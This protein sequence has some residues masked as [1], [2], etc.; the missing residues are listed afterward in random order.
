[1]KKGTIGVVIACHNYGHF[2]EDAIYS[3]LHQTRKP[4]QI[5]LSDDHSSD[6]TGIIAKKFVTKYPKLLSYIRSKRTVGTVSTYNR[7]MQLLTTDY[8]CCL[9]ADD[10]YQKD[11][12]K[13]TGKILDTIQ[14]ISIAYTDFVL[15]GPRSEH[16]YLE[17]DQPG[18]YIDKK[19]N[20]IVRF[21]DFN[22]ETRKILEH[23][24]YIHNA[25]LVRRNSFNEA[26]GYKKAKSR[27]IDHDLFLRIL[28][29]GKEAFHVP[30]PL[31]KYRQHSIKQTS[32]KYY[33]NENY[34]NNLLPLAL[35]SQLIEE[36]ILL[37]KKII[38]LQKIIGKIT[39][40]RFYKTWQTLN[41]V[42]RKILGKK[43]N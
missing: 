32:A 14:N 17:S 27:E 38:S 18:K 20:F 40:A 37:E 29:S 13:K 42:Y 16:V 7:G 3:V 15:F 35:K 11:F 25:S 12:F 34:K 21:P 19:K 36:H 23:K 43:E 5:V 28:S 31:L 30:L 26:G 10:V 39:G 41:A 1:M 8:I 4:T 9:D 6:Q 2:L 33:L 24:N 22:K